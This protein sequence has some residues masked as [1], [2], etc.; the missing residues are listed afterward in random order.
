[1]TRC[2]KRPFRWHNSPRHAG[3]SRDPCG[4]YLKREALQESSDRQGSLEP[5]ELS[6]KLPGYFRGDVF[7]MW[8]LSEKL[9]LELGIENFSDEEYIQGSQSDGLHL[10]PGAP[11]TVRGRIKL[12]F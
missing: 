11:I 3:G 12:S 10:T 6:F 1:M 9:G 2:F 4:C 8:R 5:G 7:I